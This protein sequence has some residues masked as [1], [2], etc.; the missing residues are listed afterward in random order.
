M[1]WRVVQR[2]AETG[3]SALKH[4]PGYSVPAQQH[5]TMFLPPRPPLRQPFLYMVFQASHAI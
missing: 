5:P 2:V 4:P 1:L 3:G